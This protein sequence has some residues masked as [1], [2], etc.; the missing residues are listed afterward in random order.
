MPGIYVVRSFLDSLPAAH[1][2]GPIAL[3]R[4]DFILR[5]LRWLFNM[6]CGPGSRKGD[7]APA[8][9]EMPIQI[10]LNTYSEIVRDRLETKSLGQSDPK[11]NANP[12]IA[13]KNL[14]FFYGLSQA[15]F[16]VSVEIPERSVTALIGPSGCGKSTFL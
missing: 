2:G 4:F 1:A 14:S 9:R 13:V 16:D 12:K 7:V 10:M 6:A 8:A 11:T 15:L 5:A 3:R